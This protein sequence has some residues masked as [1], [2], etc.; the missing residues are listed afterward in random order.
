MGDGPGSRK[1][2]EIQQK[3][4]YVYMI[5]TYTYTVRFPITFLIEW[6]IENHFI[7]VQ[8]LLI[9]LLIYVS[10]D[11]SM[12]SGVFHSSHSFWGFLTPQQNTCWGSV[13][14]NKKTITL[15]VCE[16]RS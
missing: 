15:G 7:Y 1:H 10:T 11:L 9:R 4:G 5:I 8:Y 14:W 13:H 2:F 3:S 6:L 12:Y 16:T